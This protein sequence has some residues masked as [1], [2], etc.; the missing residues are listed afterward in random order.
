MR[1]RLRNFQY[2]YQDNRR[3][4]VSNRMEVHSVFLWNNI[5][6][7]INDTLNCLYYG[8]SINARK[9]R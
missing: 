7:I 2:L 4:E 5:S 6:H 8:G 1:M 9:E 3:R